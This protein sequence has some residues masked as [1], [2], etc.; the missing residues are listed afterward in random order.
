MNN[1]NFFDFFLNTKSTFL[2]DTYIEEFS[3]SLNDFS[4]CGD[5][6]V[7]TLII[8]YELNDSFLSGGV[9]V[10]FF[11]ENEFKYVVMTDTICPL[12]TQLEDAE[13]YIFNLKISQNA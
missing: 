3:L 11:P 2:I 4:C 10:W 5:F 6:E 7:P 13:R 12:F 9:E 8:I 1:L